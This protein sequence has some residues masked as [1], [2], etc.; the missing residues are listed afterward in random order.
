MK[1]KNF[2]KG[3]I[4]DVS[5]MK[6]LL[7]NDVKVASSSLAADGSAKLPGKNTVSIFASLI[8]PEGNLSKGQRFKVADLPVSTYFA[9]ND[10][11]LTGGTKKQI[12]TASTADQ[13]ELK[14]LILSKAEKNISQSMNTSNYELIS[15]LTDI[16]IEKISF[17]KEVG[18]EGDKINAKATTL[19][20]KY[21]YDNQNI[22]KKVFLLIKNSIQPGYIL[23]E[24]MV[25]YKINK[26]EKKNNLFKL[27]INAVGKSVKDVSKKEII[28]SVRGSDVKRIETI[29]KTKYNIQGFD[30]K[31]TNP[32]PLLNNILPFFFNNIN[33]SISSL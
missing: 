2:S 33:I 12:K 15:K 1:K 18:E 24:E 17:S 8:G 20:T 9:I 22:G 10:T 16:N 11:S 3:T 5:G 26:I 28:Q 23:T 19:T 31:P 13:E 27:N 30:I 4:L 6:F 25:S 14:K 7:N 29:L 32:L 21:G